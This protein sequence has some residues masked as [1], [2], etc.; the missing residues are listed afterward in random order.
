MLVLVASLSDTVHVACPLSAVVL[1]SA[2]AHGPRLF[3]DEFYLHSEF[4][5]NL[6]LELA[7]SLSVSANTE[8]LRSKNVLNPSNDGDIMTHPAKTTVWILAIKM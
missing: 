6:L 7:E 8:N 1:F 3:V 5:G 2:L 4:I